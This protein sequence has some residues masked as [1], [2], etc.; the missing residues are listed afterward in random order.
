MAMTA[1]TTTPD[2]GSRELAETQ[3]LNAMGLRTQLVLKGN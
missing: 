2:R 3:P 1:G